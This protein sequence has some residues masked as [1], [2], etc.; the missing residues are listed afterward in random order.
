MTC[1]GNTRLL[2]LIEWAVKNDSKYSND[3]NN[4]NNYSNNNNNYSNKV[5]N[6]DLY[7]HFFTYFYFYL[8]VTF[9]GHG[10]SF[11]GEGSRG[12]KVAQLRYSLRLLLSICSCADDAILQDMHEQGAIPMLI[13]KSW[14]I[15]TLKTF[16]YFYFF[17]FAVRYS[18][19]LSK[20]S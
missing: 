9:V 8:T 5:C 12:S 3:S 11:H 14:K 17:F 16:M 4:N 1:Q 20:Y 18:Q 13:S 15:I 6:F 2:L 7:K 10:N 19:K